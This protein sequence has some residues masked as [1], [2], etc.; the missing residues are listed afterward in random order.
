MGKDNQWEAEGRDPVDD[1]Q[2]AIESIR[3]H[4][5][6]PP[7]MIARCPSCQLVCSF[8]SLGFCQVCGARHPVF[9]NLP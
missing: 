7:Y 1:I 3:N 8:N 4:D 5:P 9:A 2:R 6:P